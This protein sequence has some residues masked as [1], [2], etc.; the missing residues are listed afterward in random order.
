MKG[1]VDREKLTAKRK[2]LMVVVPVIGE[3]IRLQGCWA[4]IGHSV[5]EVEMVEETAEEE[6]RGGNGRKN[7]R[8]GLI[9]FPTLNTN[10]FLLNV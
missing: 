4:V 1:E 7:I 6:K 3:E 9:F 2:K 10:L 8:E 5:G